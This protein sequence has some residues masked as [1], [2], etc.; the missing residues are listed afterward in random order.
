MFCE[1]YAHDV[2]FTKSNK[3]F[4]VDTC[5]PF[6]TKKWETAIAEVDVKAMK[7]FLDLSDNENLFDYKKDIIDYADEVAYDWWIEK[8]Y[9]KKTQVEKGHTKICIDLMNM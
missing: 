4:I 6:D 9:T 1:Q 7:D 8:Q 3:I 2:I 5:K